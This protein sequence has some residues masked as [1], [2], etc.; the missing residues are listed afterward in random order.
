MSLPGLSQTGVNKARKCKLELDSAQRI[1]LLL[2]TTTTTTS[3]SNVAGIGDT[4]ASGCAAN[5]A[6]ASSG[7]SSKINSIGKTHS[8]D[9]SHHHSQ[10]C[11][12]GHES[13][14]S[15]SPYRGAFSAADGSGS[16]G[17]AGDVVSGGSGGDHRRKDALH[18]G[19]RVLRML[20]RSKAVCKV[21]E[22]GCLVRA[23]RAAQATEAL[24]DL[25]LEV[26]EL[27]K[28]T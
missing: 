16:G 3:E 22:A 25:L 6:A 8:H 23:N 28:E 17:S 5:N 1:L 10:H 24:R 11:S 21:A 4:S 7:L 27:Q 9:R 2:S 20:R 26:S 19:E 13:H 15:Q 18:E 12:H 14:A